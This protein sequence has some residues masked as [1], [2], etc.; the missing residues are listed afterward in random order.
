M[1]VISLLYFSVLFL[2]VRFGTTVY[3]YCVNIYETF[4][5][6]CV[7][8]LW[9]GDGKGN[10]KLLFEKT[11]QHPSIKYA[12]IFS[13]KIGHINFWTWSVGCHLSAIFMI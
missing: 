10:W 11:K 2:D 8:R 4:N 3:P 13:P 1:L 12:N 6:G 7:V 9:A 5:G